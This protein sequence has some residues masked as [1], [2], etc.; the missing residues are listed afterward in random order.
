MRPIGGF[1]ELE[2]GRKRGTFH[3]AALP[4]SLGRHCLSFVIQQVRPTKIYVPYYACDALLAPILSNNVPYEFYAIDANL[5]PCKQFDLA[6]SEYVVYI[7]YFGVKTAAARQLAT[8][9]RDRLI[10]DNA[11]AFYVRDPIGLCSFNSARKFFGVPDGAYLYFPVAEARAL[12]RNTEARYEH[13]VERLQGN[14]QSAYRLFVE[15]ERALRCDVKYVSTLS[16]GLLARV[17]YPL[18]ADKRRANYEL[19]E[20]AFASMNRLRI[21]QHDDVP[22]CYPLLLEL[23]IPKSALHQRDVL[24][25]TLWRETLTR[26]VAGFEFERWVTRNLLPLPLDQRYDASDCQRVIDEVNRLLAGAV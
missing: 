5:E 16:E 25:P 8:T 11:Q 15:Y 14:L 10:L 17:D 9:Y 26:P 13:L 1:L 6:E 4:L 24:V 3:E 22:L 2:L 12:E 21:P 23:E 20:R 19:Y 7:N 18:A